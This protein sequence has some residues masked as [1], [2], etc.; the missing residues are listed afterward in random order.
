MNKKHTIEY[1]QKTCDVFGFML[2]DG[3]YKDA[4]TPL[5]V[6]CSNGHITKKS[7]TH[8]N[9]GQKCRVCVGNFKIP[10]AN[11]E[12]EC[13]K[14]GFKLISRS[15]N[16]VK[17][18]LEVECQNGHRS[19]KRIDHIR[20]GIGCKF[21]SGRVK[22]TLSEVKRIID[23][24]GFRWLG[25][26]YKNETTPMEME[27]QN[28]HITQKTLGSLKRGSGCQECAGNRKKSIVEVAHKLSLDGYRVCGDYAGSND[29]LQL[30]C[31]RGHITTTMTYSNFS[32]GHRCH[33]CS[34]IC[35]RSEQEVYE[36]VSG[37]LAGVETVQNSRVVI[38]PQELDIYIPSKKLAIEYCGLYWHSDGQIASR[39][40]HRD[41]MLACKERGIR[42][43]TIFEDEWLNK[44]EICKS[45]I[46]TALGLN[47]KTVYARHTK[48]QQVDV[49][50]ARAFCGKHH[51]QGTGSARIAYGLY[52]KS[53][54][55]I[56]VMTFS[57]TSRSKGGNGL[58]WEIDRF[59][60][61]ALVVGG[62]SKL[63][64]Q[65][66]RDVNPDKVISYCDLRWGT[67]G[68][69]EKLGMKLEKCT[70]PNYWYVKGQQ[71][72][73]RYKFRKDRLVK[74]GHDVNKSERAI[75]SELGYRAIYDCGNCKYVW[76]R[77]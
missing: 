60:S 63:F 55:L 31:P 36:F 64:S 21:C 33:K 19:F 2:L 11:I 4:R 12:N 5:T 24:R 3:V 27:C 52:D 59:C 16:G 18:P 26:I 54:Q 29:P 50:A 37:L 14:A 41:K 35:S 42:L 47:G 76:V 38:P 57:K 46:K 67:G 28:G 7:F 56:S 66:L 45:R 6:K 9:S 62:A 77:M 70:R 39:N 17:I 53:D 40:Y 43:I 22:H 69:Y 75:M 68:V 73:H 10:I 74:D 48:C 15:Y 71:R 49:G 65:F 61:N 44:Q 30:V 25:G 32:R 72:F 51:I 20:S 23:C 13:L 58:D 8:I 34:V 1:I